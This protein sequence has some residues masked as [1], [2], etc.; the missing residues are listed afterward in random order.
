[1]TVMLLVLGWSVL[2]G[3]V[4]AIFGAL[5]DTRARACSVAE[6]K[7][8]VRDIGFESES[9]T[10][11]FMSFSLVRCP[12]C[13]APFVGYD[14]REEE[15]WSHIG[16]CILIDLGRSAVVEPVAA[17]LVAPL[18]GAAEIRGMTAAEAMAYDEQL[19]Q[20]RDEKMRRW[21]QARE[22]WESYGDDDFFGGPMFE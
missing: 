14:A 7:G 19:R 2:I 10:V 5:G 17:P 6:E 22:H 21:R 3:I 16:Q 18:P 12:V 9:G 15:L 4:L 20:A 13:E 1:M 11:R 8:F